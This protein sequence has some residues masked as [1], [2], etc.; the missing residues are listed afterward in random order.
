[1]KPEKIEVTCYSGY[2]YAEMPK[3]FLWREKEYRVEEIEKSWL[4]PGKRFFQVISDDKKAYKLC[5]NETEQQWSLTG[6]VG[7]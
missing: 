5:Y 1:V 2:T 4:E 7:D 6:P 3:T